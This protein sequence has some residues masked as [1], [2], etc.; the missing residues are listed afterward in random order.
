MCHDQLPRPRFTGG[1]RLS[2]RAV[3]RSS[4][5]RSGPR[6]R[7]DGK[8]ARW[9]SGCLFIN[10]ACRVAIAPHVAVAL[11]EEAILTLLK[12]LNAWDRGFAAEYGGVG[13]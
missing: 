5:G 2:C 7:R 3:L 6:T 13:G 9:L 12:N 11:D 8:G 1:S 10:M 4:L